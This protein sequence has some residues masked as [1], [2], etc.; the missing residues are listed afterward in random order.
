MLG[1]FFSFYLPLEP[2]ADEMFHLA[3]ILLFKSSRYDV[4]QELTVPPAYHLVVAEIA[5]LLRVETFS[6]IRLISGL[7]SFFAVVM[8][9]LYFLRTQSS[10]PLIGSIQLLVAPLLFPFIWLLYTDISSLAVTLLSLIFLVDRRYF[11]CALVCCISLLFRQHNIFWVILLFFM[12]LGQLKTWAHLKEIF[13]DDKDHS[14]K[15]LYAF[16]KHLLLNIWPFL[17]P[18]IGFAIFIFLNDGVALGDKG[19]QKFGGIYPLQI[20]FFLLV[21]GVVLLPLH[22]RN[23]P[24][25]LTLISKNY[26]ILLGLIILGA[27]FL[28]TFKITHPHNFPSEYFLR[29]WFLYY[30]DGHFRLKLLAY[31]LIALALLSLVVTQLRQKSDYWLYP[32]AFLALLPVSLIEQRYYIVPFCLFMLFRKPYSGRFEMI[33]LSWFLLSSVFLMQ[34]ILSLKFFL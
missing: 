22:L 8:S 7:C 10:Y 28:K 29:N 30:L 1:I 2:I 24:K 31:C 3:Q 27:I 26:W 19:N 34:G 17:I 11:W 14:I 9:Y 15:N 25:I 21:M 32:L 33:L 12:A 6:G 16:S 13:V 4:I 20:F 23:L 18:L 5:K